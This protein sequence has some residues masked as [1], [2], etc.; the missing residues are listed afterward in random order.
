MAYA[1]AAALFLVVGAAYLLEELKFKG[2]VVG[3]L[4]KDFVDA[5]PAVILLPFCNQQAALF[6]MVCLIANEFIY[7]NL[8]VGAGLF[9]VGYASASLLSVWGAF[10]LDKIYVGIVTTVS[11]I[12]PL[13]SVYKGDLKLKIGAGVY[14]G[15]TLSLLFYAFYVTWNPG[16]L[17]LAIGDALLLVG[18][19]FKENK[20]VRIVSD[21]FYF[22][23][24]CFVPLSLIG[25]W[26]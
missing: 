7:D 25:G 11:V 22:F 13:L 6:L 10:D 20:A 26:L 1:V 14:G 21:L 3:D 16:F 8:F 4:L 18:E 9:A 5:S 19:I 2:G 24:T 12:V 15:L 23:G 17:A